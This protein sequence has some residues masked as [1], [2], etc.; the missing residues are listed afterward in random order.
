MIL[1]ISSY[2]KLS[3]TEKESYRIDLKKVLGMDKKVEVDEKLV[4]LN[5]YLKQSISYLPYRFYRWQNLFNSSSKAMT[6]LLEETGKN[7]FRID[8]DQSLKHLILDFTNLSDPRRNITVKT[9]SGLVLEKFLKFVKN[10]TNFPLKNKLEDLINKYVLNLSD[11]PKKDKT[12]CLEKLLEFSEIKENH[13]IANKL[14]NLIKKYQDLIKESNF[15]KLRDKQ[16]AHLENT[17]EYETKNNFKTALDLLFEIIQIL[18]PGFNPSSIV[19]DAY[20]EN[21]EII[22]S[23]EKSK[24]MEKIQDCLFYFRLEENQ[25]PIKTINK[26]QEFINNC[27]S[28]LE[29][30]RNHYRDRSP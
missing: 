21:Q 13:I 18:N 22:Y 8:R 15:K 14:E 6:I 17:T 26:I 9:S 10:E 4:S 24:V 27:Q 3:N 20:C 30:L 19:L 2:E 25:D 5:Y 11:K 16:I 29:N 23:L 1:K 7:N 28:N 12:I